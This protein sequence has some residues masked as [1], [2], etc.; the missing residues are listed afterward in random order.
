MVNRRQSSK[1]RLPLPFSYPWLFSISGGEGRCP[2][3]ISLRVAIGAKVSQGR[4]SDYR[5]ACLATIPSSFHAHKRLLYQVRE[6]IEQ[7]R[8]AWR[9]KAASLEASLSTMESEAKAALMRADQVRVVL[10]LGVALS[11]AAC[12]LWFYC[13]GCRVVVFVGWECL[14]STETV[15]NLLFLGTFVHV[16]C[17]RHRCLVSCSHE[18][19]SR[20]VVASGGGHP[21][22]H[23]CHRAQYPPRKISVQFS[24]LILFFTSCRYFGTRSVFSWRSPFPPSPLSDANPGNHR[25]E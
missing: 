3:N 14:L 6:A 25:D 1:W 16:F 7:E 17:R 22:C 8:R 10:F 20:A 4:S 9:D 21:V 12:C 24:V 5:F 2:V 23:L 15:E 11:V 19:I 18:V 13:C